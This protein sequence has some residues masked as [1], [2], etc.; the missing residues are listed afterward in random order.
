M[1]IYR[2]HLTIL[3]V[4]GLQSNRTNRRYLSIRLFWKIGSHKT[5]KSRQLL[6]ASWRCRINDVVLV[7][8]QRPENQGSQEWKSLKITVEY[9]RAHEPGGINTGLNRKAWEPEVPVSEGKRNWVFSSSREW[10]CPFCFILFY[11][12]SPWVG[13]C[14]PALVTGGLLYSDCWFNCRSLLQTPLQT[15]PEK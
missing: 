3:L 10:I 4:R 12:A 9:S 1:I 15:Y 5:E 7:Q 2:I 6:L 11:S 14:S 8:T 13:W